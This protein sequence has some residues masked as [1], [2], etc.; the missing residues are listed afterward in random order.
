MVEERGTEWMHSVYLKDKFM[1][2]VGEGGVRDG[3]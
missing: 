2:G 1:V 3:S